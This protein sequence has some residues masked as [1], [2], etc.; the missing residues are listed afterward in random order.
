MT[1]KFDG[2]P[3]KT[4]GP[5]SIPCQALCI[6]SKP[7]VNSKLSYSS[8]RLNLGQNRRF[9]A[10]VTLKFNR[11]PWKP[12]GHLPYTM[13]SF[14]HNVKAI[15]EFK[16]ELQSGNAKF[17]S[18]YLLSR[19]TLKFDGWPWPFARIS[20]L[21]LVITPENFMKIR[22]WEHSEKGVTDGRTDRRK[23]VFLELLGRS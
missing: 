12:I 5:S 16:M 21:S 23:E 8:E 19:V 20:F 18:I 11:W 15:G 1:W 22:W 9:V 6:I 13:S 4:I 14:V 17:G 7:L 10:R 2:R 3:K